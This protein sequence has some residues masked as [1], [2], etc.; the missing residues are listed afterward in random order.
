[1]TPKMTTWFLFKKW[2]E[3]VVDQLLALLA[4]GFNQQ[5]LL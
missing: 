3:A 2:A 5:Q 4:A 1:M